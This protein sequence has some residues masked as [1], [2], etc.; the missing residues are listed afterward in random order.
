MFIA[1]TGYPPET[2]FDSTRNENRRGFEFFRS[3]ETT[4]NRSGVKARIYRKTFFHGL[5]TVA[6][7]ALNIYELLLL[8]RSKRTDNESILDRIDGSRAK[9]VIYSDV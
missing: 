6:T 3:R 2:V 5:K 4:T 9:H 1:P 8:L 7:T